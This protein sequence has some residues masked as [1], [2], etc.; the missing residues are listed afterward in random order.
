LSALAGL[1]ADVIEVGLPSS[2]A[3]ADGP[4]IRSANR[5]ALAAGATVESVFRVVEETK[6]VA[7]SPF[8]L[9]TYVDP[10]RRIGF[11]AFARGACGAGV[12][13]VI[14]P[15]L[16]P[17]DEDKWMDASQA[18]GLDCI[19]LVGSSASPERMKRVASLSRGF[20]YYMSTTGV[21]GGALNLSDELIAGIRSAKTVCDLPVAVGFGIATPDDARALAG[22]ADGV[23]VGSALIRA[24]D[25]RASVS[26][27]IRAA[28]T[29]SSAIIKALA[30]DS[31]ENSKVTGVNDY[32]TAD[33]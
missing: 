14:I 11:Q 26:G 10:V 33:R 3:P 1:G 9:M 13:G 4:T 30:R 7:T 18:A 8:V 5:M 2:D 12:S 16:S 23:I 24:I 29:L 31:S 19:F 17:E 6:R 32:D 20:L 27:Q 15:D 25:A 21:T 28:A 22:V